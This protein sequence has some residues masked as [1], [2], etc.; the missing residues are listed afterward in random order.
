[1]PWEFARWAC[2]IP[3]AVFFKDYDTLYIYIMYTLLPMKYRV[4]FLAILFKV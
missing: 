2:F 1:M 4:Y 3:V